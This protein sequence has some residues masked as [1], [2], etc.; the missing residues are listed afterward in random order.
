MKTLKNKI[1]ALIAMTLMLTLTIT[2][3]ALPSVKAFNI[4]N[5]AFIA[6]EPN[7]VGLGQNVLVTFWLANPSPIAS[8]NFNPATNWNGYEVTV[9]SPTG[10]VE[11][12]GPYTSD[13]TGGYYFNFVPTEL[14]NYTLL[15]TFPGQTINGNYYIPQNATCSLT[16]QKALIQAYPIPPLPT[17]YWTCPIY[18]ENRGWY[19][20][21]GNWFNSFYNNTVKFNPYTT[22]P[23][24]AHIVWA[25]EAYMGGIVGGAN[26]LTPAGQDETYYQGPIYQNYFNPP[27]IISGNLYYLERDSS[28]NA[29]TGLVCMSLT[30]GKTLWFDPANATNGLSNWNGLGTGNLIGQVFSPNEPNGAGSFPYIWNTAGPNWEVFDANTGA[31]LYT[32]TNVYPGPSTFPAAIESGPQILSGGLDSDNSMIAYYIDGNNLLMWN[33]TLMLSAFAGADAE[34]IYTAPVGLPVNW[35]LG[36]QWNVTMPYHDGVQYFGLGGSPGSN[37]GY[38]PTDGNVIFTTTASLLDNGLANFTV[39]AYSCTTGAQLW[40]R[41]APPLGGYLPGTTTFEF[42]GTVYD[43]VWVIY[44]RN[45]KEWYGYDEYTGTLLWGP[46]APLPDAW[47]TFTSSTC[48]YDKLFCG[49]YAGNIYCFDI[50]NGTLDWTCKLPSSGYNTPYGGYPLLG[51]ITV[52]DGMI[53]AA[54]GEHTPDSP[55]WLGG[56][57]WCINATTGNLVYEIDGYYSSSPAIADGYAV[58][59][60]CYNGVIDCFGKGQTAVTVSA[61][62]TAQPFGQTVMIKGTVMDES[63]GLMDYAGNSLK[64]TATPAIGDAYMTQYMEYLYEQKP[65]P[66]NTTGVSV[67]L[68][69]TD[70]NNNTYVI[71]QTTSNVLGNFYY[72]WTPSISGLYTITATFEGSGSYYGSEAQTAITVNQPVPTAAPTAPPVSGLASTGTV[73]LGI[74]ALAIIIIIIGAVLAVLT[75]RKRP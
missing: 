26:Y 37:N 73:E 47:D 74:A 69:E 30:T 43:G 21:S 14:G 57:M 39:T 28:G 32:I 71:G 3:L 5:P 61:P 15:F 38:A 63:P 66:T 46:T 54:A 53:Y 51:G 70:S 9:T 12:F 40:S 16:V 68:T 75:L 27:L 34:N 2:S 55:T 45:T 35:E 24:T 65:L 19:A 8:V 56:Q 6:V 29:F 49:T 11:S 20:I 18:G 64:T 50:K 31:L 48:G 58:S 17:S 7:P 60:N 23:T 62:D 22:A 41:N 44:N 36:V 1:L 25:Y 42:W 33:S 13:A 67:V 72:D 52:A 59:E 4:T 10:K